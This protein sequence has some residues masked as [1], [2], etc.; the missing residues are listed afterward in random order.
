LQRRELSDALCR[1][2]SNEIRGLT[3]DAAAR[4]CLRTYKEVLC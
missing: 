1:N 4:A 2:G 3:W